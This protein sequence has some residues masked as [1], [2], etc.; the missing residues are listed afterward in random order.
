VINTGEF[1]VIGGTGSKSSKYGRSKRRSSSASPSP[2]SP[3][4]PKCCYTG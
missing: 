4:P 2:L 1:P 3:A